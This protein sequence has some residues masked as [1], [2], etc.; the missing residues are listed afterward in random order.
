MTAT[1]FMRVALGFA[2][3]LGTMTGSARAQSTDYP[4]RPIKMLVGFAAGGGTDVAAR[5][6]A[7]KM[8]EILGQTILVEN[9]TGAGGLIAA[10]ILAAAVGIA[11]QGHVAKQEA[12]L[13][14]PFG[15]LPL[16]QTKMGVS[17]VQEI[18]WIGQCPR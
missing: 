11:W 1:R 17:R 3:A 12:D 14:L 16:L 4:N 18:G 2:F 15:S 9:R 10:A 13:L 5:I 7:Q 8:S 6:M